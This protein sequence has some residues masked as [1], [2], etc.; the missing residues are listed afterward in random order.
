MKTLKAWATILSLAGV[1]AGGNTAKAELL[2]FGSTYTLAADD[3]AGGSFSQTVTLSSAAQSIGSGLRITETTTL[4]SGGAEFAEFFITTVT[5]GPIFAS[6]TANFNLT[7]TGI[8]LLSPAVSSNYYV[9][10]T[11]VGVASSPLTAGSGFGAESNPNSGSQ[12]AGRDALFFNGFVPGPPSTT[13]GINMFSDP[14]GFMG[15]L[16]VDTV[17][18][19]G[20]FFGVELSPAVPE[21]STWAMMI[22]G[23]AGIG[24]MAYRR[25]AKPALMAA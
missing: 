20:F 16:G 14:A 25:K 10:A 21:P 19:N 23:F 5:G 1:L 15:T 6:Q 4:L 11:T 18:A 7:A 12:G 3:L 22:L 13:T 9:D 24:F 17:N 2:N 8:Q